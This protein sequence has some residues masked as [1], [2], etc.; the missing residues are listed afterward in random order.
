MVT[1]QKNNERRESSG[2]LVCRCRENVVR[3]EEYESQTVYF[4]T[5]S[6]RLNN[7]HP[8]NGTEREGGD[9][10]GRS[11]KG[12]VGKKVALSTSTREGRAMGRGVG[13]FE[14]APLK[15]PIQPSIASSG[16]PS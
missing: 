8:E 5:I 16:S 3:R 13:D 14:E 7:S 1:R 9:K 12:R 4:C 10:Q 2:Q 6:A 15:D 11:S